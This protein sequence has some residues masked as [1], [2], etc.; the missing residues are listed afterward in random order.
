MAKV[1]LNFG[2]K[3]Q[4][5]DKQYRVLNDGL[6][7]LKQIFG[8]FLFIGIDGQDVIYEDN[9]SQPRRQDGTYPQIPTGEVRGVVIGVKSSVQHQPLFFTVTDQF[10]SDIEALDL[11]NREEVELE[12]IVVTYSSVG[13]N[14]FKL[15]AS[16]IKK[17]GTT[18][19]QLTK[20]DKTKK[21]EHKN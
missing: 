10:F 13:N 17:A 18:Q 7:D 21:E 15:F 9:L 20:Q 5:A 11:K 2:E 12:D 16:C 8:K 4:I 1:G 6:V 14:Q 19:S 3:V